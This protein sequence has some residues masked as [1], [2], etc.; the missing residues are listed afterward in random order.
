M[1]ELERELLAYRIYT[2]IIGRESTQ[3][4]TGAG[5][6]ALPDLITSANLQGFLQ[7]LTKSKTSLPRFVQHFLPRLT[8]RRPNLS[9]RCRAHLH[10]TRHR[11]DWDDGLGKLR[12][13]VL[14]TPR[15]PRP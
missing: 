3:M 11:R 6:F 7:R 5:G 15:E 9:E 13:I 14:Q 8:S 12:E 10:E 1:E 2:M 4:E